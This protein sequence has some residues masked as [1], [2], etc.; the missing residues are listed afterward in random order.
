M[1][2]PAPQADALRVKRRRALSSHRQAA[3]KELRTLDYDLADL[4]DLA[5][6]SSQWFYCGIPLSF[7]FEFDHKTLIARTPQSHRLANLCC[8]CGDCNRAKGG[9]MDAE[10][11]SG[12]LALLEFF[13]PRPY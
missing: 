2:L 1:K 5:K 11:F 9:G 4:I 3:K 10:E 13:D 7:G 6:R 12:L 8:A